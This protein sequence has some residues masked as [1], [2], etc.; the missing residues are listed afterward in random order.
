MDGM[1]IRIDQMQF[2]SQ[3]A[4][5]DTSAVH[6]ERALFK[7]WIRCEEEPG[8]FA[9]KAFCMDPVPDPLHRCIKSIA[10]NLL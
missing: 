9:G 5:P 2:L 3:K 10:G 8:D 7:Q 4:F 1:G 6:F